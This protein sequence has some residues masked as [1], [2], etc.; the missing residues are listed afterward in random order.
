MFVLF[1]SSRIEGLQ[2]YF[3]FQMLLIESKNIRWVYE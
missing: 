1:S 3:L 2:T